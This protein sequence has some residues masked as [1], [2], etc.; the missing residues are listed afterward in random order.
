VNATI[1]AHP[2]AR[3]SRWTRARILAVLALVGALL[4][5][6]AIQ[7][8]PKAP[9]PIHVFVAATTARVGAPAP[10]FTS[11]RLAGGAVRLSQYRGRPVLLNFWATWCGPCQDEMPLIQRA[12]DRYGSVG[13][14]VLAV[15]YQQTDARAMSA[16]LKKVNARF[17]GVYDPSGQ[18]AN[19][20]GV[21]V[22]L[23][24]SVFVDRA[25]VISFIQLGQMSDAV[26]Q[27]QLH[28][29]L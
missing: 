2:P 1:A 14:Q 26:L 8:Q 10:D 28:K 20:Y 5:I 11:Q 24:V 9:A 12:S 22:G 15:N 3:I 23:P 6:V 7:L 29:I 4:V 17:P 18:I 13:L 25:G 21:R 16:F 19:A 27:A